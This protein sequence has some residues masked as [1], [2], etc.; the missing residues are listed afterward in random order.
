MF[1]SLDVWDRFVSSCSFVTTMVDL[2][3][4]R[5]SHGLLHDCISGC[6]AGQH[7]RVLLTPHSPQSLY[8]SNGFE[9]THTMYS[10]EMNVFLVYCITFFVYLRSTSV[11]HFKI[12]VCST[13]AFTHVQTMFHLFQNSAHIQIMASLS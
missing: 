8:V 2:A 4:Q 3:D 11:Y 10:S 13:P 9:L 12:T 5:T 1:V 7:C 6:F